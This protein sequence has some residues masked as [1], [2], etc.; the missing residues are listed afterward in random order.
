MLLI[1]AVLSS[2]E[3]DD[4]TYVAKDINQI[5]VEINEDNYV[6]SGKSANIKAIEISQS[7]N[8]D[9]KNLKYL[10]YSYVKSS[11]FNNNKI[12]TLGTEKDLTSKIILKPGVYELRFR[13]TDVDTE[14]F[15]EAI[16]NLIVTSAYSE[17]LFILNEQEEKSNVCFYNPGADVLVEN[18]YQKS[19]EKPIEGNAKHLDVLYNGDIII[20]TD[21]KNYVCENAFFKHTGDYSTIFFEK[22]EVSNLQAVSNGD[23]AGS[24]LIN[25]GELHYRTRSNAKFYPAVHGINNLS[26]F[27]MQSRENVMV[28]DNERMKFMVFYEGDP[29]ALSYDGEVKYDDYGKKLIFAQ[30]GYAANFEPWDPVQQVYGIF[31]DVEADEYIYLVFDHRNN[32]RTLY[33]VVLNDTDL[34]RNASDLAAAKE[35]PF[36][37]FS[38]GSKVYRMTPGE[39]DVTE[40]YEAPGD[41]EALE[42][43]KDKICVGYSSGSGKTGGITIHEI[44]EDGT[45]TGAVEKSNICGQITEIHYKEQK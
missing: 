32:T 1:L 26:D 8:K 4:G 44:K 41:I 40:V 43:F 27:A 22:P 10:W 31:H 30:E 20:G 33:E 37:Y 28:Y 35:Q 11:S 9:D 13:V 24:Y 19:N 5:S 3:K 14:V 15:W 2:C 29:V 21:D 36:S 38:S 7:L 18:A 45:L 39:S 42:C 34:V 16:G 23:D 6:V 25:D 17:G 12:D